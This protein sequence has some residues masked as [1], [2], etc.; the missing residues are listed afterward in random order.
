MLVTYHTYWGRGKLTTTKSFVGIHIINPPYP[1]QYPW[2]KKSIIL[3]TKSTAIEDKSGDANRKT[4]VYYAPVVYY[5][6]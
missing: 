3:F 5:C 2:S 4:N 1:W 6:T